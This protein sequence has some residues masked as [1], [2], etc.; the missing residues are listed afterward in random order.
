MGFLVSL[1]ICNHLAYFTLMISKGALANHKKKLEEEK[2][3]LEQE[4]KE[5]E[6]T[7][8]FG[9]DTTDFNAEE[10]D[11]AEAVSTNVALMQPLKERLLDVNDA[12]SKI[13]NGG[14][15]VCEK[16]HT[17][18]DEELLSVNPESRLCRNCKLKSN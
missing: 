10:A 15:G 13:I 9:D 2:A 5:L 6:K 7:P 3:T 1:D 18:I 16:C 8:E 14:Y 4:I 12:L 17:E 11:E